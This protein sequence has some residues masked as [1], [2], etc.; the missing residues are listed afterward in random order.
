M[1]PAMVCGGGPGGWTTHR[2]AS[3][4]MHVARNGRHIVHLCLV[5]VTITTIT[6]YRVALDAPSPI[7]LAVRP[8][9]SPTAASAMYTILP[10]PVVTPLLRPPQPSQPH[11]LLLHTPP[12]RHPPYTT[13]RTVSSQTHIPS[14][15]HL[16][17]HPVVAGLDAWLTGT[18][19]ASSAIRCSPRQSRAL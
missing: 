19:L 7:C 18:S 5:T 15:H 4:T 14:M 10:L 3:C 16:R 12:P 2:C 1:S 17:Y 9:S 11:I 6:L 13:A 8:P